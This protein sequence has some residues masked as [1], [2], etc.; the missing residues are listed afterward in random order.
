MLVKKLVKFEFD[1]KMFE[2]VYKNFG[3]EYEVNKVD[4]KFV[5]GSVF[6]LGIK[7]K[8]ELLDLS[9]F[10]IE[11][12][13]LKMVGLVWNRDWECWELKIVSL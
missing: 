4:E 2:Y 7:K 6:I 13:K 1:L 8:S 12:F 10:L 5:S 3:D 11:R 9:K